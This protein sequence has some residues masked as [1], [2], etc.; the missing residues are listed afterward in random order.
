MQG[1]ALSSRA[2]VLT[3]QNK[4]AEQDGKP[5][6]KKY[7]SPR[8]LER[9]ANILAATR[10][11]L[12]EIG[13]TATT[14]RALA[15]KA[16]V[17]PG[18]LYNLYKSKDELL[19]A[20]VEELLEGL[21]TRASAR[22]GEGVERIVALIEEQ[23]TSI[24]NRPRYAEAMARALFRAEKDDPLTN[25]LYG[26]SLPFLKYHLQEAQQAGHLSAAADADILSRRIQAQSWGV[27]MAWV[28]GILPLEK[29][30]DEY[31]HSTLL[32]LLSVA[33]GKTR[34]VLQAR[35]DQL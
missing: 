1:D 14:M 5:A 10:E 6:K 29:V 31:L 2:N 26:R 30:A 27:I 3:T 13:Y 21:V 7:E 24:Q 20:A 16:G 12:N 15:D 9:Q 34:Q 25:L 17:A 32:I 19:M 23:A 33:R 4:L 35:F 28:M 8:Q 22:S 11:M 18:T